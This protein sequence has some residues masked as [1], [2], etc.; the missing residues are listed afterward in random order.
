MHPVFP[1]IWLSF[2]RLEKEI[3]KNLSLES[4]FAL[5]L[6]LHRDS[7]QPS[8]QQR[9]VG[10]LEMCIS[11]THSISV[12]QGK[13]QEKPAGWLLAL[14]RREESTSALPLLFLL[15]CPFPFCLLPFIDFFFFISLGLVPFWTNQLLLYLLWGSSASP[16][17][18]GRIRTRLFLFLEQ[19]FQ[20]LMWCVNIW[21]FVGPGWGKGA[22]FLIHII[23]TDVIPTLTLRNI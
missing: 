22:L 12:C 10:A 11:R 1:H 5:S 19:I 16:N 18:H 8:C 20:I 2:P 23:L 15:I 3:K 21:D 9:L 13:L 7:N 6:F 14:V 17:L 4:S